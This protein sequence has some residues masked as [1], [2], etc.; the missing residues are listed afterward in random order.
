L[1]SISRTYQA[2]NA[3]DETPCETE[4]SI[5]SVGQEASRRVSCDL[6]QIY[7]CHLYMWELAVLLILL[8]LLLLIL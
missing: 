7:S 3:L 6:I 2:I 8:I 5:C 1:K 4:A